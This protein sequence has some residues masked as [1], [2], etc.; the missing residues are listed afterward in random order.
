VSAGIE[1]G[2]PN[3]KASDFDTGPNA[4]GECGVLNHLRRVLK[5]CQLRFVVV[6]IETTVVMRVR[7]AR[8]RVRHEG[9]V[10]CEFE[11]HE[12]LECV[13]MEVPDLNKMLL[14]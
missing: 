10:A 8:F 12:Q 11:F 6:L 1:C 9:R 7:V 13:P 2:Y 3:R 4:A 5:K 14:V